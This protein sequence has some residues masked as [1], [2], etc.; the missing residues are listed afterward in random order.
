M[1]RKKPKGSALRAVGGGLIGAGVGA[2]GGAVL[3]GAIGGLP[4]AGL[5]ALAGKAIGGVSGTIAGYRKNEPRRRRVTGSKSNRKQQSGLLQK[6]AMNV[7][8]VVMHNKKLSEKSKK[9]QEQKK[10]VSTK[11]QSSG[12]GQDANI[13]FTKEGHWITIRGGKR[14]FVQDKKGAAPTKAKAK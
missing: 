2:I 1:A 5:G 10:E 13:N 9:E 8:S 12:K 4:G 6:A 11:K 14:I 7:R 3:G